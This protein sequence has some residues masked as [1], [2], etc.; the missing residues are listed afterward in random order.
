LHGHLELREFVNLASTQFN[1]Q[2]ACTSGTPR[3]Q[4]L[5]SAQATAA[6]YATL[7]FIS[8]HNVLEVL[9][10]SPYLVSMSLEVSVEFF[11]GGIAQRLALILTSVLL[12]DKFYLLRFSWRSLISPFQDQLRGYTLHWQ[13][14]PV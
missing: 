1:E 4:P 5:H 7:S 9:S 13:V 14:S 2:L 10:R 6:A 3:E 8:F 11:K 12:D